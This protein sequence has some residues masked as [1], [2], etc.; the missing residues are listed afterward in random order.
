MN[1]S[2][3]K[4]VLKYTDWSAL[5]KAEDGTRF[6]VLVDGQAA[7]AEKVFSEDKEDYDYDRALQVVVK[8]GEQFFKQAGWSNVGSHCY[9]DYEP[10]WGELSEVF[11]KT[12]TL[13]YFD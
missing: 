6:P 13:V 5:L 2:E 3:A 9:G 8:I 1:L 10:S 7:L 12:K 11:P 4:A